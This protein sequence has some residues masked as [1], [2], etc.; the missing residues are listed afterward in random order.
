MEII[1]MLIG[2][3]AGCCVAAIACV[4]YRDMTD[5]DLPREPWRDKWDF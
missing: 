1:C 4:I 2:A 5:Q 3:V